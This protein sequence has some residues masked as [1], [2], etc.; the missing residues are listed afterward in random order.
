MD[1]LY[2]QHIHYLKGAPEWFGTFLAVSA[3]QVDSC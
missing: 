3:R 2:R 1:S